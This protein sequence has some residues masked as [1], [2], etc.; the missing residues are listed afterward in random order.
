[1]LKKSLIFLR[2]LPISR[3]HLKPPFEQKGGFNNE[4]YYNTALRII[5]PGQAEMGHGICRRITA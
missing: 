5:A 2:F 1:M 3:I 4:P